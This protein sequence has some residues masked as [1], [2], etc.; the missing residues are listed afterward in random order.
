[1]GPD[2]VRAAQRRQGIE[3]RLRL[4]LRPRAGQ[5]VVQISAGPGYQ[6]RRARPVRHAFAP[7][8]ILPVPFAGHNAGRLVGASGVVE[9]AE[10]SLGLSRLGRGRGTAAEQ[11]AQRGD[12]GAAGLED[13]VDCEPLILLE[14]ADGVVGLVGGIA[15]RS[16]GAEVEIARLA[17]QRLHLG[18]V[19][20]VIV[21]ARGCDGAVQVEWIGAEQ[22]GQRGAL[23]PGI[24]EGGEAVVLLVIEEA[25]RLDPPL[26]R[27]AG[28]RGPLPLGL[29]NE[30]GTVIGHDVHLMRNARKGRRPGYDRRHGA[31]GD[32]KGKEKS[33]GPL[34]RPGRWMHL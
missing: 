9:L 18:N 33:P 23:L 3:G 28:P 26:A 30:E 32:G 22:V 24:L 14:A 20:P 34:T 13:A 21:A 27:G 4:G 6:G 1:M 10:Q 29:I 17:Q 12:G 16:V 2:V 15:R 11:A 19:G 25:G 8:L 5:N 31:R 7:L